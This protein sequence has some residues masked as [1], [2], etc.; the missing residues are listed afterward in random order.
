MFLPSVAAPPLRTLFE[1]IFI[2]ALGFMNIIVG[3]VLDML[4]ER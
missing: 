3:F 2:K 4:C 1:V